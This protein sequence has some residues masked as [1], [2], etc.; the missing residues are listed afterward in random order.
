MAEQVQ[1]P[2]RD[3][4]ERAY[5][6]LQKVKQNYELLACSAVHGAMGSSEKSFKLVSR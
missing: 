5:H 2:S 1:V 6:H 3:S 4:H